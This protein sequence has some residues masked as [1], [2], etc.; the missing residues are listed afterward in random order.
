MKL[1]TRLRA[2]ARGKLDDGD[3]AS[4]APVERFRPPDMLPGVLPAADKL[5][6]DTDMADVYRY[7]NQSAGCQESFPGYPTLAMLTQQAEYR[8][9]SEKTAMAMVRKW[10]KLRS[11]GDDD[12]TERMG[13]IES[14]MTRLKVRELFGECAK[15]DGWMGR[16]QL[17]I[18]MGEQAGHTLEI[19]LFMDKSVMFGKLR[20]F[21]LIEAMYTYPNSYSASNPMA[22][23]YY[24]PTT[25]F[26]M[27]QKVHSSR[28]LTF[29]SRP[30]PDM[31]KPA[32]NFGGISMS[33]LAR[34]YVEN[35]LKTRTSVNKL[36]SNF[37]TSGL[38]TNMGNVLAGDDGEDLLARAQMYTEI[39]DNQDL[40]IIDHETEDFFQFNV[41]LTTIDKLQA[42]A[43]EH[44]AS[45]SSMPLP[46]LL[47]IT[48]AGLNASSDGD[49]R[50]FHEHVADMQ[51]V[52]FR[53]N[54]IKVI[55]LIQLSKFG[56]IDPE[57]DFD[58]VPLWEQD[59]TELAANRKSDAEASAILVEMGAILPEEVRKKL[60]TDENSGYNGLDMGVKIEQSQD[61][62]DPADDGGAE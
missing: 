12:K 46:I 19:G 14:E 27:G 23:D 7:A 62:I 26:V 9:L 6:M 32:Y 37:S 43:Q 55:H 60:A 58:F 41:P 54:L 50:I 47:G 56:E 52:V 20:K 57:I 16:C 29:V 2:W 17:F 11:K 34:P 15:Q 45:V 25:W 33:Q 22:D 5:A 8:M 49:V 48:P 1:G 21:K 40:M 24:N 36:L 51:N 28:L 3:I 39:R 30:V 42:Q 4:A 13:K 59:E 10:V 44:M 18:D 53:D 31:L 35:W 38:K 61:D